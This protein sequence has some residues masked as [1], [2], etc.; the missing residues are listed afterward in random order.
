MPIVLIG[1]GIFR[2]SGQGSP[3][4][5][6][7]SHPDYVFT[8]EADEFF[9]AGDIAPLK[10]SLTRKDGAT[11]GNPTSAVI[12]VE[13]EAESVVSTPAP[14]DLDPAPPAGSLVFAALWPVLARGVYTAEIVVGMPG[15]G[16]IRSDKQLIQVW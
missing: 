4:P 2:L 6:A 7:V 10:W 14:V 3:S 13:D 15:D 16:Q 12:R 5:A 11:P 8:Y 1:A 9:F